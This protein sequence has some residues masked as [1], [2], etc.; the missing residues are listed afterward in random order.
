MID[1]WNSLEIEHLMLQNRFQLR[2]N[3]D[4]R[5]RVKCLG[6]KWGRK[7]HLSAWPR[8]RVTIWLA[9]ASCASI[10]SSMHILTPR[11]R[12][13]KPLAVTTNTQIPSKTLFLS[14][15]WSRMQTLHCRG[16]S[17]QMWPDYSPLWREARH[18]RFEYPRILR[19][20]ISHSTI[21]EYHHL[22]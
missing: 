9:V 7:P 19:G 6:E 11:G 13:C 5:E 17:L 22:E 20:V 4:E 1:L 21:K 3:R 12:V 2:E 18:P 10:Q 14:S 16:P 8:D 15:S